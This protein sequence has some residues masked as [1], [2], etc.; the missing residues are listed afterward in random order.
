MQIN[1]IH[2]PQKSEESSSLK[3]Q[4]LLFLRRPEITA[5]DRL[6]LAIAGLGK[7]YRNCTIATLQAKY[8]VSHTFVYNQSKIL[9]QYGAVIFSAKQNVSQTTMDKLLQSIRFFLEGKL[10]TKSALQGLS[11]LANSLGFNYTS[12]N[13]ISELLQIAGSLVG[14]TYKSDSPL[15]L[16]I[17]CDEV[18]SGGEAIL[19]TLEAQSMMVLD[20]R[21]VKGSL[22]AA[23]WK[24][25]FDR[26]KENQITV[27]RLVKDQGNQ[28][29]CAAN[30]LFDP[31][32]SCA[33]IFHAVPHRLGIFHC[34]L[35]KDVEAAKVQELD[36]AKR[37]MNTKHYKTALKKEIEWDKA[38]LVT[39][40]ATDAL[41]QFDEH[42]FKMIRQLRPFTSKGEPRDKASGEKI[43]RQALNTLALLAIPTLQKE[44]NHIEGLLNNGQL[45]RFL[46][47]V[48]S[49][50]QDLQQ[51]LEPHTSWLWMLYWQWDKKSYQTHSPKVQ[52]QAKEEA[53]AAKELLME[54]YE[55]FVFKETQSPFASLQKQVFTTLDQIVLA[56]SL[57]ETFNSIL[58]P[59]INNARGQV[60][61]PILNLVKFYHNHR[62]FNRGKRQGK[63]PIE[64]LTGKTL[65][66]SWIDLLMDKIELAFRTHHI[67]SMKELHRLI[68]S[69]KEQKNED[70]VLINQLSVAA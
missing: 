21:L 25:S 38:K 17:L 54:Y 8:K 44:L 20:I 3:N 55:Q 61:Q 41:K 32:I 24:L 42:Y 14:S 58:K 29:A 13:F 62:V 59:F 10:E 56:S 69:K 16:T 68:C 4:E 5:T 57:V 43:I 2:T 60:S 9:K 65:D 48:P 12:T 35:V 66:K 49:L 45:L 37:F 64:L 53:L 50:H 51:I 6:D 31:E 47:Q 11:N 15:V 19:V 39:L 22:L 36:R 70:A 7:A 67:T 30:M 63:A 33:D 46:D 26:I 27:E 34:R 28:M 18:Y 23:D 1:K 52:M 40:Q